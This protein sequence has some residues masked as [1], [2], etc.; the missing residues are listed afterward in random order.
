MLS[1][2]SSLREHPRTPA[3]HPGQA[4]PLLSLSGGIP[5]E[6]EGLQR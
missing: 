4:G 1:G 3:Q 5:L 6:W 2:G